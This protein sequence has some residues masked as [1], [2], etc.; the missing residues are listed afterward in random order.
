MKGNWLCIVAANSKFSSSKSELDLDLGDLPG[1]A[2]DYCNIKDCEDIRNN[3]EVHSFLSYV[4]YEV[5]MDD[6]KWCGISP[7]FKTWVAIMIS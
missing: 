3:F 4:N 5:L 1:P 6:W 7:E 2:L